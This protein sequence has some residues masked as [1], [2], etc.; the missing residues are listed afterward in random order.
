MLFKNVMRRIGKLQSCERAAQACLTCSLKVVIPCDSSSVDFGDVADLAW[1]W[2][3]GRGGD[4]HGGHRFA[5]PGAL[6]HGVDLENES[7]PWS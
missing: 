1:W 6:S 2:G 4:G 7:V 3:W 5:V